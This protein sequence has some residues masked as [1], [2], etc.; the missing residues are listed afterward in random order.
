MEVARI[1]IQSW[2]ELGSLVVLSSSE[3][4]VLFNLAEASVLD[5]RQERCI[6]MDLSGYIP[7]KIED[8][9]TNEISCVNE[10]EKLHEEKNR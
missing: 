8:L 4:S 7:P 3:F 6:P 9:Q 10:W 5:P 2:R 1:S